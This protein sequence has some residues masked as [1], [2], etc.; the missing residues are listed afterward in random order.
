MFGVIACLKIRRVA[1]SEAV[2]PGQVRAVVAS[3]KSPFGP[4]LAETDQVETTLT[5]DA[6]GEDIEVKA[7]EGRE[8]GMRD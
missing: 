2:R 4:P 3:L 5:G 8:R 6:G 1:P 7:R